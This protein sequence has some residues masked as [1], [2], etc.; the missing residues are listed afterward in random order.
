MVQV[1][2]RVLSTLKNSPSTEL[3]RL[4]NR[5]WIIEFFMTIFDKEHTNISFENLQLQLCDF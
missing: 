1:Q 5:D 2:K 4:K 3:L